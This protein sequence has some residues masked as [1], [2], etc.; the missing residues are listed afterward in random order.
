MERIVIKV[1]TNLSGPKRERDRERKKGKKKKRS[2]EQKQ[3]YRN[4]RGQYCF[5]LCFRAF[6][7]PL[8]SIN[9]M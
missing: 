7:E 5:A 9:T 2:P 1:R 3:Q 8:V 6:F 4:K